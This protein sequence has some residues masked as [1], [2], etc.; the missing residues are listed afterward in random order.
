MLVIAGTLIGTGAAL[1]EET[2]PT[3]SH[4]ADPAPIPRGA[5]PSSAF[6]LAVPMIDRPA[7]HPSY[8]PAPA[9]GAADPVAQMDQMMEM[10]H[11]A[12]QMPGMNANDMPGMDHSGHQMPS[13]GTMPGMNHD[14]TPKDTQ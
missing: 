12:H 4:P 6:D 7:A 9:E 13:T 11:S 5:A 2:Q 14:T 3:F 8:G 10:D 1:A